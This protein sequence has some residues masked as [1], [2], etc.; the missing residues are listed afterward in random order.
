M[1]LFSDLVK[2]GRIDAP[3]F[4]LDLPSPLTCPECGSIDWV[5]IFN[6]TDLVCPPCR[7]SSQATTNKG[8]HER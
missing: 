6:G 4:Y 8:R 3:D 5:Y 7:D 1:S 2:R